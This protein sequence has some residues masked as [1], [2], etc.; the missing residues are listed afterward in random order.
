MKPKGHPGNPEYSVEM[1]IQE[2]LGFRCKESDV[3]DR[4]GSVK[5]LVY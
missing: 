2:L 5:V 1:E 3:H 4:R